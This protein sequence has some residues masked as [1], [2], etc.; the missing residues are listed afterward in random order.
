MWTIL[1][2]IIHISCTGTDLFSQ[3]VSRQVS[4]AR[5]SLTSVFGM[6]TGGT[7]SS[8][9]P[10]LVPRLSTAAIYLKLSRA[11]ILL[12]TRGGIEPPLPA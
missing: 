8:L 10:V 1:L 5:T 12:V 7:S 2:R 11:F 3:A 6:G 4:S 9:A